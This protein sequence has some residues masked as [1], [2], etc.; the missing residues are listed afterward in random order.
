[1]LSEEEVAL[2]TTHNAYTVLIV[3]ADEDTQALFTDVIS[4]CTPYQSHVAKN[5]TEAL[6]FVTRSCKCDRSIPNGGIG[7]E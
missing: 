4:L 1:M 7:P 2:L 3:E 5:S 6:H